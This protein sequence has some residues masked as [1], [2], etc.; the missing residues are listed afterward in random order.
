M[1]G[2]QAEQSLDGLPVLNNLNTVYR[3]LK[4]FVLVIRET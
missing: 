3:R 4:K 2:N 1:Q